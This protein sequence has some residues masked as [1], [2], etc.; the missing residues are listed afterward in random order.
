VIKRDKQKNHKFR[1]LSFLL[2]ALLLVVGL[3]VTAAGAANV[4]SFSAALLSD[5]LSKEIGC[6]ARLTYG[7]VDELLMGEVSKIQRYN[8]STRE[9]STFANFHGPYGRFGKTLGMFTNGNMITITPFAGGQG[10]RLQMFGVDENGKVIYSGTNNFEWSHSDHDRS[11]YGY[12][13]ISYRTGRQFLGYGSLKSRSDYPP[14]EEGQPMKGL[15]MEYGNPT[16]GEWDS[17]TNQ[18]CIPASVP[19]NTIG[20]LAETFVV[21]DNGQVM[22]GATST[23]GKTYFPILDSKPWDGPTPDNP[24]RRGPQRQGYWSLAQHPNGG[25]LNVGGH[26][27]LVDPFVN[28]G[29]FNDYIFLVSGSHEVLFAHRSTPTDFLRARIFHNVGG[30]WAEQGQLPGSQAAMSIHMPTR[31][32]VL[33][34]NG[35]AMHFYQVARDENNLPAL[36]RVATAGPGGS[37]AVYAQHFKDEVYF[38]TEGRMFQ[39]K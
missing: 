3:G 32:P 22:I 10:C 31:L 14:R 24:D 4:H 2:A 13:G 9:I 8:T 37:W 15:V 38:Y 11:D 21:L 35:D 33:A 1:M 36:Y 39:L 12:A 25:D 19:H 28:N 17:W 34:C 30:N 29:E 23:N 18:L 20:L 6:L 26:R 7:N 5:N 16:P 27:K